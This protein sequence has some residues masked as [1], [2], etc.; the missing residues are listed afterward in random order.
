MG[1]LSAIYRRLNAVF[2]HCECV[3]VLLESDRHIVDIYGFVSKRTYDAL[4]MLVK[5]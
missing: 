3:P 1:F 5:A 4:I 2:R